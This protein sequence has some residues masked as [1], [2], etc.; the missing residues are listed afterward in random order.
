M[1]PEMVL[2]AGTLTATFIPS[3]GG[4]LASLR[5]DGGR[6]WMYRPTPDLR[7]W[8]NRRG[9]PFTASTFVGLDECIPTIAACRHRNRQLADHG[10]AWARPWTTEQAGATVWR[11]WVDLPPTG[12]RLERTATLDAQGLR[13]DYL[14]T[15]RGQME[16]DWLWAFHALFTWQ[17]GDRMDLPEV[18]AVAVEYSDHADLAIG[19]SV[20][21]PHPAAGLDLARNH[22]GPVPACAKLI[23]RA[24][25]S[26]AILAVDGQRLDLA[27]DPAA[28][29]WLGL[30]LTR[31]GFRGQH[32]WAVEPTNGD[33][34]GLDQCRAGGTGATLAPG[35]QTVWSVRVAV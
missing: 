14:L 27:W 15:N 26:A 4:R 32:G 13:L 2:R 29:P 12:L 8:T 11:A 1:H 17:D 22:L 3:L 20:P 10:E 25:G 33:H 5:R 18:C 16:E 28:M 35:E 21:W 6:E 30:W 24:G 7:L 19:A 31:G 34:D 23:A 9:D